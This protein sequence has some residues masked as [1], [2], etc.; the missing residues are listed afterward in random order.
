MDITIFNHNRPPGQGHQYLVG[1]KLFDLSGSAIEEVDSRFCGNDTANRPILSV[2]ADIKIDARLNIFSCLS[3][4]SRL[5]ID[6]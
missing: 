2:M 5:L 4:T 6:N 1:N 3:L